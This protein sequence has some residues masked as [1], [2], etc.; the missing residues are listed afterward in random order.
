[1]IIEQ[2]MQGYRYSVEPFLLAD[3][4]RME[5]GFEVLDVGSG[6]GIIPLLLMT[7]EPG[8]KITAVEIQKSLFNLARQNV[9]KNGLSSHIQL[10]HGDF[11]QVAATLENETFD[12][13]ISN[14]PYRKVN[15]GRTNPNG[16]KAIARHELSLNL[17]SILKQSASLLKPGGKIVL[18]YPPQRLDEVLYEMERHSMFPSRLR[19]I[20]GT[21]AADAKI[22]LVEGV[23]GCQAECVVEPPLT[24]CKEDNSYTEEMKTIYDSFNHTDRPDHIEK[25]RYGSG[26]G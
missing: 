2:S 21:I 22:F 25:K 16:E 6:C 17:Q 15:T 23:K 24:L 20:H 5:P 10:I 14:P 18:A 8:L 1:M 9:A 12:L 11:L 4:I 13:A 7:L 19:F 3:F 26:S